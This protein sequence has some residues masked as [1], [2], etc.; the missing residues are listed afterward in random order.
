MA[1]QSKKPV[2]KKMWLVTIT[3]LILVVIAA[4]WVFIKSPATNKNYAQDTA[5]PLEDALIKAGLRKV[6]DMG[7]SGRGVDNRTPWYT[8]YLES[9]KDR[10]AAE[11]LILDITKSRG[12]N[13]QPTTAGTKGYLGDVVYQDKSKKSNS[14]ELKE[15]SVDLAI[16]LTNSGSLHSC[17]DDVTND[18]DNTAI[19][20]EVR[21][22]DYK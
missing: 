18:A 5:K 21:L 14:T 2:S 9:T 10:N 22:P 1:T 6:C 19:T 15:G 8:V 3:V 11:V 13:I 17:K 7:D 4:V 12:F 16:A 20:L